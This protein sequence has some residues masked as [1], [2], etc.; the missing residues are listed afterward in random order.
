MS[1][2]FDDYEEKK[3]KQK[4]YLIDVKH[5]RTCDTCGTLIAP[6]EEGYDINMCENCQK[7]QTR[8]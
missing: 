7:Y 2:Q 6:G 8:D 5:Y 3:A 1:R 4:R